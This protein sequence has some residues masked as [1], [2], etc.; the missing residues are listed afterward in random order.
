M[1][2]YSQISSNKTKTF[3]IFA[4][5]IFLFSGFFYLIDIYNNTGSYYLTIGLVVSVFSS[6]FSYYFSDKVVLFTLQ[7]IPAD[8]RTYFDL[9]TVVENLCIS[10]GLP[11]PKVYV[12][13]DD[14]PNAFA[15]G[16]DP[17]H[18]VVC[19]TTGLLAK[20][21]RSELEGVIS[22]ELSHIKNYDILLA[23]VVAV[24][25]GTLAFVADWILRSMWWGGF[26]KS[27]DDDDRRGSNP[28]MLVLVIVAAIL[29]PIIATLIQLAMSRKREFLADA[30][31]ALLT[32][33]PEGLARALEKIAMDPTPML[34]AST[35]T[36]HLFISN[37]FK[38][39]TKRDWLVN[40][41]STHP[42]TEER[43]KML[44]SM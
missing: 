39:Q 11:P 14:A 7:A 29:T 6:V 15:T 10:S 32:R 28:L 31:G 34:H 30:S 9:Y 12:I 22:H 40:L 20:L 16:R 18:S 35:S 4:L 37:P 27:S 42:A 17:K 1:T 21:N 36:A 43:I 41:F 19:V 13:Q 24:L 2:I 5:F 38:R 3:F 44:R 8:K 23:S 25:V 33:H 26:K